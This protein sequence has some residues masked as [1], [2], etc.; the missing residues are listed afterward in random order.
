MR[1]ACHPGASMA[2]KT[3]RHWPT[4]AEI[5]VLKLNL[6]LL[7]SQF[8]HEDSSLCGFFF[9][10]F[11][12]L[13]Q[14]S[15]KAGTDQIPHQRRVGCNWSTMKQHVQLRDTVEGSRG[16]KW[17]R[18]RDADSSVMLDHFFF[19]AHP[20]EQ[21]GKSTM[22]MSSRRPGRDPLI[23]VAIGLSQLGTV[24]SRMAEETF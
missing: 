24:S 12:F 6:W 2:G 1:V 5:R 23:P 11:V 10:W 19:A 3:L 16:R 7:G 18:G 4:R 17:A 14:N 20:G 21:P 22:A 8:Q 15:T 13:E 9:F